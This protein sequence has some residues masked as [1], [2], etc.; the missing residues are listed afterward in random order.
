MTAT[1]DDVAKKTKNGPEP[2]EL[3]AARELV[4]QAREQG[5]SLTRPDGVLKKL[6]RMMLERALDE[7]L[8]E[9]LGHPKHTASDGTKVRD[10][11]RPKTVPPRRDRACRQRRYAPTVRHQA[12]KSAH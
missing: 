9:H 7:E 1:L 3:V 8:T 2:D 12:P 6:T 5:L 4:R 11:T 10:G